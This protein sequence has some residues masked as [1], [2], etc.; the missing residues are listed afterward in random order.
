MIKGMAHTALL[1]ACGLTSAVFADDATDPEQIFQEAMQLRDQGQ[2][3]PAIELFEALL[4]KQPGLGRAR[5]EL[6]VAYHNA[7]RFEEARQ[8]LL[9]VL[10]DPDTPETVRLSVSAYLAQLGSD[11]KV[12]RKRTSSSVYVSAGLFTD[13]NVN[14][15]PS[16]ETPNVS[17]TE[18]D[19]TGMAVT[20]S[21]SHLSRAPQPLQINDR[22]VD[23]EWH[24]QAT[25]YSKV[26]S[27]EENDYNVHVLS[28]RTGPAL[29]DNG[30]WR[31]SLNFR[32]D[33]IYFDD[34]PYSFN[35]GLN[36]VFALVFDN[37]TE[38]SFEAL[39]MVRE[40]SSPADQGLDG[41]TNMLGFALA[42]FYNKPAIGV[43]AGM[44]Y[45][46]NGADAAYLNAQ[47][48]EIFVG[49]QMPAWQDARTYL[50]LSVRDYDYR[51]ADPATVNPPRDETESQAILGV[52]HDFTS[53]PLKSWTLNS[54]IT[55]TE[56]TSNV[57]I[58][59]Y[60]RTVFEINMRSYF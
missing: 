14:L 29:V 43:E 34:N 51:A 40:F 59:E 48:A 13:S 9:Q 28:L 60:D 3:Y 24:S 54:Q 49:G 23:M 20:A 56:N 45:H 55:Y 15:G 47:G 12:T 8:Q 39:T 35:V 42:K 25:A 1:L 22:A 17:A 37:D 19:G 41:S 50:Q 6:A 26:Y 44:R 38:I 30:N 2:I 58:F 32:L 16:P 36:P 57:V 4:S 27:G 31:G 18:T 21:I 53:G 7:R 10:N 46:A 52:S 11:E 33:K 5:L